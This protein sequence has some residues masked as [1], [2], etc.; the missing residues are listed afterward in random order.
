MELL[1]GDTPKQKHDNLVKINKILSEIA[2]PRRGTNEETKDI[3]DFANQII[4]HKLIGNE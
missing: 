4:Q 3:Q 2:Y 1:I